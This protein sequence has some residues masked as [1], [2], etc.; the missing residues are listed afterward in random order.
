[1]QRGE[2][3]CGRE[4]RVWSSN[5]GTVNS[6][7]TNIHSLKILPPGRSAH[8]S[9]RRGSPFCVR[10]WRARACGWR[11][12]HDGAHQSP[13][14]AG[15]G[16]EAGCVTSPSGQGQVVHQLTAQRTGI[17]KAG[18]DTSTYEPEL[19]APTDPSLQQVTGGLVWSGPA[20]GLRA[21]VC[22]PVV[23]GADRDTGDLSS[24][25]TA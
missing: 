21:A 10:P 13:F 14:R 22:G 8:G 23:S 2:R 20:R 24:Q 15:A 19:K 25:A 9:M 4:T 16:E 11:P 1:M 18:R 6:K 17:V 7:R 12:E 5:K 3:T